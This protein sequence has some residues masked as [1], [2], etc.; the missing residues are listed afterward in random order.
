VTA[1]AK[2]LPVNRARSGRKE[3]NSTHFYRCPVVGFQGFKG[4]IQHDRVPLFVYLSCESSRIEQLQHPRL[5]A[6]AV[7]QA[8]RLFVAN[9]LLR[10]G[11]P[12]ERTLE[13]VRDDG[14]VDRGHRVDR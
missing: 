3:S 12:L 5:A 6:G 7:D 13:L 2:K 9:E 11:V 8:I 14:D 10:G 4:L 1:H